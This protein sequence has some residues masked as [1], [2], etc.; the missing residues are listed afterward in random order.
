MGNHFMQPVSNEGHIISKLDEKK[1]LGNAAEVD[2][3]NAEGRP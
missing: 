2:V 3:G 1:T